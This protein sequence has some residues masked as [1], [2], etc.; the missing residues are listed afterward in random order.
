MPLIMKQ[1]SAIVFSIGFCVTAF[2]QKFE[3]KYSE[4]CKLEIGAYGLKI[5]GSDNNAVYFF[6]KREK[7][8]ISAFFGGN[9][10][11]II[12]KISKFNKENMRL[13]LE[14]DYKKEL[15]N[16]D[17]YDLQC[18]NGRI[19]LF[20]TSTSKKRLSIL[21]FE[22]DGQ[23]LS[24]KSALK[25]IT[26]FEFDGKIEFLRKLI[27]PSGDSSHFIVATPLNKEIKALGIELIDLNLNSVSKTNI[28][29]P[30]DKESFHLYRIYY[31]RSQKIII[32]GIENLDMQ[33]G[34]M[35]NA[36]VS[37][38]T[39]V[40]AYDQNG[41]NLYSIGNS[42]NNNF[43]LIPDLKELPNNELLLTGFFSSDRLTKKI[44]GV[45]V[46]KFNIENGTILYSDYTSFT[47][48]PVSGVPA[49]KRSFDNAF[50]D[51]NYIINNT[52][53]TLDEKNV[54]VVAESYSE[55]LSERRESSNDDMSSRSIRTDNRIKYV[56]KS[57][58]FYKDILIFSISFEG[59]INWIT[60][61]PK[62]QVEQIMDYSPNQST[63]LW[64]DGYRSYASNAAY[65]GSFKTSFTNTGLYILLNDNSGNND[66]LSLSQ[67]AK[68]LVGAVSLRSF[69]LYCNYETG[70]IS[71]KELADDVDNTVPLF[72]RGVFLDNSIYFPTRAHTGLDISRFGYKIGKLQLK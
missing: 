64:N 18:L 25:E 24:P 8:N 31:T 48:S 45:L 7:E 4:K 49:I 17:F 50:T 55:G 33:K 29:L 37:G 11:S 34:K 19:F 54:I 72:T 27:S 51:N 10:S 68:D 1:I 65:Y 62:K 39:V 52:S 60:G 9:A 40:L 58:I 42:E 22:I 26:S 44:T 30:G 38:T 63:T 2:C 66:V 53:L 57:D 70:V 3:L 56:T 69:L 61:L 28:S 41:K 16:N 6:E 14:R 71:R 35:K 67:K 13:E 5:L 32:A 36:Q 20:C 23:T 15:S 59:K 12:P 46:K 47:N 43:L 21:A